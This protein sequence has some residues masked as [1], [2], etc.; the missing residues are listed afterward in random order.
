MLMFETFV[1]GKQQ[2]EAKQFK[3][4]ALAPPNMSPTP[5]WSEERKSEI[6]PLQRATIFA[7]REMKE[8]L[9]ANPGVYVAN[10]EWLH[11]PCPKNIPEKVFG[12]VEPVH[13]TAVAAQQACRHKNIDTIVRIEKASDGTFSQTVPIY[14]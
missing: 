9:T 11:L 5:A 2:D 12:R 1:K 3:S 4:A 8:F 10:G 6:D 14:E 7:S 13:V